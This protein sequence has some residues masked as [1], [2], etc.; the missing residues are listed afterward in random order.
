VFN[1]P[2]LDA[3]NI[4]SSR[5][6]KSSVKIVNSTETLYRRPGFRVLRTTQRFGVANAASITGPELDKIREAI[7]SQNAGRSLTGLH[8]VELCNVPTSQ[9]DYYTYEQAPP[10]VTDMLFKDSS[11]PP[12]DVNRPMSVLWVAFDFRTNV[13]GAPGT[14]STQD[15]R[16]AIYTQQRVRYE[17]EDVISSIATAEKPSSAGHNAM[18]AADAEKLLG[19]GETPA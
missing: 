2:Y 1:T 8:E 13:T 6:L 4:T 10:S 12:K 14:V 7:Y 18:A 3:S 11:S 15:Y 16:F 17:L 19:T 9:V 5:A